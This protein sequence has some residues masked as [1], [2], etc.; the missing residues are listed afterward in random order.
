MRDFTKRIE[1]I[2]KNTPIER[3]TTG[4]KE[5]QL[6]DVSADITLPTYVTTLVTPVPT[7]SSNVTA[8]SPII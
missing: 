7:V 4:S 2:T 1:A 8:V 6:P 5:F 3:P